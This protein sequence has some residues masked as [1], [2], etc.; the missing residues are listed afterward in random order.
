MRRWHAIVVGSTE[1]CFVVR[2]ISVP[3]VSS[4]HA[5]PRADPFHET[6]VALATLPFAMRHYLRMGGM[7]LCGAAEL[8][9]PIE[10]GLTSA[11]SFVWCVS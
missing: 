5:C 8:W 9:A 1:A 11:P 3:L 10:V 7:F 4:E 6:R 2:I